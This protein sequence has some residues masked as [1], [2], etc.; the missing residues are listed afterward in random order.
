[1]ILKETPFT[2]T[3]FSFQYL[4]ILGQTFKFFGTIRQHRDAELYLRFL[5]LQMSMS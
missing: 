3:L 1:M 5:T 2:M 4:N